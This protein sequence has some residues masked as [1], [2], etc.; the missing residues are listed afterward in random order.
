VGVR[1]VVISLR[2]MVCW[3][4]LRSCLSIEGSLGWLVFLVQDKTI[5]ARK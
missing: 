1:N 2:E 3:H 4:D 5:D